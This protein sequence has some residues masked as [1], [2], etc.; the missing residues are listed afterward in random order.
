MCSANDWLPA[1]RTVFR[2]WQAVV[3][4]VFPAIYLTDFFHFCFSVV[5]Y[6][7]RVGCI[8]V[9]VPA[10][11]PAF[12]RWLFDMFSVIFHSP[13]ER[14]ITASWKEKKC[15]FITYSPVSCP[16]YICGVLCW[17]KV[18]AAAFL[19]IQE[20]WQWLLYQVPKVFLMSCWQCISI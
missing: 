4:S 14:N 19:Q 17:R 7:Y 9:V 10:G 1:A 6:G 11:R 5:T 8:R 12:C 2:S 3:W 15:T 20:R 18:P 16:F 13:H